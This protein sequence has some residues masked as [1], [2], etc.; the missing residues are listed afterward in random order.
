[1]KAEMGAPD[2]DEYLVPMTT[3]RPVWL[4]VKQLFDGEHTVPL[5]HAHIVYDANSIL[6]VGTQS[7]P[8]PLEMLHVGQREPDVVLS[9]HTILPGLIDAHAH[10]FLEGS[11]Q[12]LDKRKAYL[13]QIPEA[14]LVCAKTRL[15]RILT[16]GVMA[17]RDAGDRDGV[18]LALSRQYCEGPSE[19]PL[20]PYLDSPG[21]A[22]HHQGRYGSFM[23]EPIEDY[24]SPAACVAA[25]VQSGADRIK[26]IPTGI[27]N[28]QKGRVTTAPQMSADEVT[29]LVRAARDYRRQTFAH[30]SGAEGIENAIIGGV[31]S[32]E[33]G[34]F[35]TQEQLA[36]M[37]DRNIAWVPTFVP[38]RKQVDHRDYMGWNDTVINHL[39]RILDEH[40]ASLVKAQEMGVTIIAGSDAGSWGVPHAIGFFD[41]LELMEQAGMSPVSVLIAATGA[42]AS[43][44]GYHEKIGLLR[45]GYKARFILTCADPLKSMSELRR[46]KHCYFDGHLLSSNT[47]ME[48]E[49]L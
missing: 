34:Y 32:I 18:G 15:K 12:N 14:L 9:D 25:R 37:R 24:V 35:V 29:A 31:D 43:R 20:M 40:A 21:P 11:E 30:A 46:P 36:R 49:G 42:S 26:L 39:Q 4:Q 28:F 27:I 47:I 45:P 48:E 10:L 17:V 3:D 7:Q 5:Y 19:R 23:G 8:P 33:H 13:A 38:V 16:A 44:L 22:I 1:M 41:E 6:Y 2:I